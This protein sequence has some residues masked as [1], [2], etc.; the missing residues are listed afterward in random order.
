MT[1]VFTFPGPRGGLFHSGGVL[2]PFIFTAALV[3]LDDAIEWAATRRRGWDTSA[4]RQVFGVGLVALAVLVSG[5]VYYRGIVQP[6]SSKTGYT[7]Y[8]HLVDWLN[9]SGQ[10]EQVVMV[11]DPPG[12]WY[13]GG[14][15]CI[16]VPN[17]PVE[18]VLAVA[19]RYSARYLIL[20][21]NR[22]AALAPLYERSMVH[23]R[24]SPVYEFG[25]E[26]G[27]PVI[28]VRIL[29]RIPVIEPE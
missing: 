25:N 13:A 1:F 23:P 19:D 27:R 20:D 10:I 28:V 9:A 26:S 18:T 17:E 3:G 14:G 22:P 16:A 12:Y 8:G 2:L 6:T 7:V 29:P 4:A 21:H 24:L 11:A 15:P 5:F